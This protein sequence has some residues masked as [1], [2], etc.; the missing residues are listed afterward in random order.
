MVGG[1]V[2]FMWF[3]KVRF[4]WWGRVEFMWGGEGQVHVHITHKWP[5]MAVHTSGQQRLYID[6]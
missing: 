6:R 2:E 4:M 1:R 3:G 5:S